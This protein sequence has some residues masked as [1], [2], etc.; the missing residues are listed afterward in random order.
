MILNVENL[1]KEFQKYKTINAFGAVCQC[2][3]ETGNFKSELCL[4]A[5][6]L[7]GIKKGSTW[8]GAIYSKVSWEQKPDGT[9]Y[10]AKSDFRKYATVEEFCKDYAA[11]IADGYPMSSASADNFWGYFSGLFKGK[12]GNWATDLNYLL[13]LT[14]TAIALA[15][16]FFGEEWI[17]KLKTSLRYADDNGRLIAGHYDKIEQ[18]LIT[19]VPGY[20]NIVPKVAD[21][22]PKTEMEKAIENAPK[23]EPIPKTEPIKDNPI[24]ITNPK[25]NKLICID[26]GHGGPWPG[27]VNKATGLKEKDITLAVSLKL[28]NA[29]KYLGFRTMFTRT[30]DNVLV[31]SDVSKDLSARPKLANDNNADAFI[32]IHCNAAESSSARGFE[33]FTTPGQNNS[34]KLA[35]EIFNVWKANMGTILRT[36]L[37]DGDPDKEANFAVIRGTKSISCLIELLFISNPE[38]EKLLKD[39]NWQL[40][41]ADTIAKGFANY[42]NK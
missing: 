10:E 18:K 15:P 23:L 5:N 28:S 7:A 14:E 40:K 20:T 42:F 6:N 26:P 34:D 4:K 31:K 36:D 13:R 30:D 11:K 22:E 24:T 35:T 41:A 3:H 37:S 39:T 2:K 16:T 12:Y 19:A 21:P 25:L 38:D 27:A 8:K 32:S 17:L 1:Y 33:I 29:L 9:K